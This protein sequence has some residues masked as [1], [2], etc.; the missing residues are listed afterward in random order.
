MTDNTTLTEAEALRYR[1]P[2]RA[3][4][5]LQELAQDVAPAAEEW[6]ELQPLEVEDQSAPKPFPF[7][8]LGPLLGNAAQAIANDVQA[9]DAMA[10]GSVLAAAALVAQPLADVVL[11]HG[12]KRPI[13]LFLVTSGSSGDRKSAVD[14]VAALAIH[15]RARM[16]ARQHH[17]AMELYRDELAAHQK[18]TP[19]PEEPKLQA[20]T[21]G[22]ATVEGAARL[23]KGQSSVGIFSAEGGEVLG[24]HSL[25]DASRMGALAFFLKGWG[26]EPLSVLRGGAGFSALLGRRVSM[27]LMVQP[28]LLRQLLA[29]P[30]ADGQGF[31]ARC[32]IAE[33]TSLAGQRLYRGAD[34]A[35]NP[36]VQAYAQRMRELLDI[37]PQT[38][39]QGDGYEL[40]PKELPLSA[41]A[42]ALW[43][44]FFNAIEIEQAE[45]RELA[46]ARAFASKAAEQAAR[47]AGVLTMFANPEAAEVPA[48]AMDGAVEAV[49]F[50]LQ[51]HLRLM[52]T[53]RTEQRNRL[54]RVLLDWMLAQG[55]GYM[56]TRQI[57]QKAPRAV[58]NL[59]TQGVLALLGELTER[60]YIRPAGDAWE[61]RL[62]V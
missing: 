59:K 24:G 60:G 10:G 42:R 2:H 15:E 45:E 56:T 57:A 21:V 62:G 7:A 6:P 23:L 38:H 35:A 29:D 14:E 5:E 47:I 13:S 1:P 32:L 3:M 37:A 52:G 40:Q 27:S 54:L 11:P 53:G 58:R 48:D 22:N 18:G 43:I 28:L 19:E 8:A 39:P 33:P 36:A 30:L 50:Y 12:Q 31:L 4:P 25:R 41:A 9:P 26:G 61:V 55:Y 17:K 34:P 44:A 49:G 16:Q 20:L 51:E 46:G